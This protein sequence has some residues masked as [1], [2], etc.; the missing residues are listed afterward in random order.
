VGGQVLA[1]DCPVGVVADR[2]AEIR[3]E[4]PGRPTSRVV[5]LGRRV[6]VVDQEED[7]ALE[8]LGGV[9]DPVVDGEADL[10]V[11]GFGRGVPS[12]PSLA[13]FAYRPPERLLATSNP[14]SQPGATPTSEA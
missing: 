7:A 1:A 4:R 13:G 5:Q 14:S 9:A 2:V 10:A 8:S 12:D 3:R 6:A 11:L